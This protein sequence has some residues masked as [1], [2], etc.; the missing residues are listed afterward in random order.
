[1]GGGAAGVLLCEWEGRDGVLG[2][3]RALGLE[4]ELAEHVVEVV[5]GGALGVVDLGEALADGG[6]QVIDVEEV[7]YAVTSGPYTTMWASAPPI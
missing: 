2:L 4:V 1:L 3:F 6:E 5:V 7:Q